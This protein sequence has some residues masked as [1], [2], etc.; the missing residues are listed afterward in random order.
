MTMSAGQQQLS[1]LRAWIE[2]QM[3][4]ENMFSQFSKDT[5]EP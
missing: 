2:Q 1:E 5:D 4:S 3:R